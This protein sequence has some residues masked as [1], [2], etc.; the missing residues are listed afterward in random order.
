LNIFQFF[1][2]LQDDFPDSFMVEYCS[3]FNLISCFN[4]YVNNYAQKINY[5]INNLKFLDDS[6]NLELFEKELKVFNR[7]VRFVQCIDEVEIYL[8]EVF[9]K[10]I[11]LNFM[12]DSVGD[13]SKIIEVEK[14][15]ILLNKIISIVIRSILNQEEYLKKYSEE[16]NLKEHF[17]EWV[18]YINEEASVLFCYVV[19]ESFE[20]MDSPEKQAVMNLNRYV[21]P[22]IKYEKPTENFGEI[23]NQIVPLIACSTSC[24]EMF[25][26]VIHLFKK[27]TCI[28]CIQLILKEQDS[29]E[30]FVKFYSYVDHLPMYDIAHCGGVISESVEKNKV[31]CINSVYENPKYDIFDATIKSELVV[32]ILIGDEIYG[33]FN[34]EDDHINRFSKKFVD[35]ILQISLR[36]SNKLSSFTDLYLLEKKK[37]F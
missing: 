10:A 29:K 24:E 34:F 22:Y 27:I 11:K 25:R 23:L 35:A 15:L 7:R 32:P 9:E 33:V 13:A 31:I 1:S 3:L 37:V 28:R 2:D 6:S 14:K 19:K 4:D 8:K 20:F 36:I 17:G 18:S 5:I 16:K 21:L 30:L 26:N 12:G